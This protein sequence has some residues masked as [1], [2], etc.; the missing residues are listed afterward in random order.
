MTTNLFNSRRHLGENSGS[1]RRDFLKKSAVT[2]V[3]MTSS[4][5][6]TGCA[7]EQQLLSV[8]PLAK[9]P[10]GFNGERQDAITKKYHLGN[11]ARMYN[12]SLMRF[13]A[14]D[15]MSPFGKGGL[16]SYAYAL[17]DPVNNRDPSGHFAISSMIIG[18]IF[19]AVIGASISA[20]AEGIKVS[21]TGQKFD[22]SQVAIGAALGAISGGFGAAANGASLGV[23]TGLAVA[24]ALISG[25]VDFG[26]NVAAG[27]PAKDATQNAVIGTVIGL[28]TFGQSI[29]FGRVIKKT[30]QLQF[31]SYTRKYK[32]TA[33]WD[34][35]TEA[36]GFIDKNIIQSHGGP[37]MIATPEGFLNGREFG[38][39]LMHHNLIDIETNRLLII[40]SCYSGAGGRASLAQ[41]VADS[42]H[43][44]T[45]GFSGAA[46]VANF[47]A[48]TSDPTAIR[49]TPQGRISSELSFYRNRLLADKTIRKKM[50]I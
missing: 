15:N 49:F 17:G 31:I 40:E 21:V 16:N 23:K 12:P 37:G 4:L 5:S 28:V 27:M 42:T 26:L 8:N 19:G 6:I 11:G 30:K 18:M 22:W 10:I 39:H 41:G 13:H 14:A 1:S 2:M 3:A 48:S 38:S 43:R 9:N 45:L 35:W 33:L 24:D 50:R 36:Y 29:G 34:K 7:Q 46:T 20:V 47:L 32:G 25:T 44:P